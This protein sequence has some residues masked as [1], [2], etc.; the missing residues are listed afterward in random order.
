MFTKFT[1]HDKG[2]LQFLTLI[3][4]ISI[5]EVTIMLSISSQKTIIIGAE[6]NSLILPLGEFADKARDLHKSP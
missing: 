2:H 4:S 5:V 6:G 3:L 1:Q